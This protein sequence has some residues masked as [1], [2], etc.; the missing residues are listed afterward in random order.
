MRKVRWVQ[1]IC[2]AL[3]AG[4]F[5]MSSQASSYG[6]G[7]CDQAQSN[8]AY[9]AADAEI[10][11]WPESLPDPPDAACHAISNSPYTGPDTNICY[12]VPYQSEPITYSWKDPAEGNQLRWLQFDYYY[13][14]TPVTGRPL[15]VYFHPNGTTNHLH[16]GSAVFNAIVGRALHNGWGVVS[17]EFRHPVVDAFLED[18]GGKAGDNLGY[19]PA[20]D[21]GRAIQFLREHAATLNFDP[22]NLFALGYSRGSLS[23]WQGLQADLARAS[24]N[25]SSIPRA[26]Y[27]YQSQTTYRCDEYA[28]DFLATMDRAGW[29]SDCRA[30]N[31][32]Y[33]EFGSAL[34]SVTAATDLP[35][36]I[37][38]RDAFWVDAGGRVRTNTRWSIEHY[39]IYAPKGSGLDDTEHYPDMGLQLVQ[40]AKAVG[41]GTIIDVR[42]CHN[43]IADGLADWLAFFSR[44]VVS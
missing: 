32:H 27:G 14:A 16:S 17:V 38:Y 12:H 21:T 33:L 37:R 7:Q 36:A 4:S 26:F 29:I 44:F 22:R 1:A 35:I 30:E 24:Y 23:L 43:D 13:Q 10:A 19:L 18:D 28:N 11:D 2:L 40:R 31:P 42:D 6:I 41:S 3:A 15:L 5:T 9:P 34:Q 8:D 25:Y 39:D 20:Y